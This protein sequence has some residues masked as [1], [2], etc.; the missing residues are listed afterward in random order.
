[1][2]KE[3]DNEADTEIDACDVVLKDEQVTPDKE[4]PEP[5]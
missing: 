4:L 2:S 1:M 3:K 5:S